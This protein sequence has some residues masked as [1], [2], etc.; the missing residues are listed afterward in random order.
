MGNDYEEIDRKSIALHLRIKS[1]DVTANAELAEFLL[2]ILT[3]I[4]RRKFVQIYD[5][6]LV[7][8]AVTDA[9]IGTHLKNSF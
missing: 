9:L 2:P 8:S 4:L 6:D 3:V 5:P 7:D 1:G